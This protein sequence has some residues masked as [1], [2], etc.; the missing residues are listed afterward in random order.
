MV[1]HGGWHVVGLVELKLELDSQQETA[2]PGRLLALFAQP[3][4]V[5]FKVDALTPNPAHSTYVQT[6]Q[7]HATVR[8]QL[9]AHRI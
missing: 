4:L 5:R 6:A 3:K 1:V 8:M 2:K 9:I 7:H